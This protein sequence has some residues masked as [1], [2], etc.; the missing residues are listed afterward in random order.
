LGLDFNENDNTFVRYIRI[1][2]E[3]D[4]K[5]GWKQRTDV[6]EIIIRRVT[7]KPQESMGFVENWGKEGFSE[8]V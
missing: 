1:V 3:Y 4:D 5:G 2:D 7:D 6:K 8:V